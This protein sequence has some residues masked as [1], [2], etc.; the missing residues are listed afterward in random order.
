MALYLIVG[1]VI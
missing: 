1:K